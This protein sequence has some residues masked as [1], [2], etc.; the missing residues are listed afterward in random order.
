MHTIRVANGLVQGTVKKVFEKEVVEF[1]CIPYCK[2]PTNELRFQKPQPC[3]TFLDK[4]INTLKFE[5]Y[6]P[7]FGTEGE[8]GENPDLDRWIPKETPDENCLYVNV[9]CPLNILNENKTV[10]VFVWIYGGGF[11]SGSSSLDIYNGSLL[12]T[13]ENIIV[14]NFNYRLGMLGFLC[15]DDPLANGNLGIY[16]QVLALRWIHEN[17]LAFKGDPDNI[18]VAGNS[19]GGCSVSLH[20]LIKESW[21]YYNKAMM[22]S[23]V[24]LSN[25][26]VIPKE[27]IVRRSVTGVNSILKKFNFP[28]KWD[29]LLCT[30]E[31]GKIMKF[32][33]SLNF[34]EFL[35]DNQLA[36]GMLQF[37]WV[38]CVDGDLI[39]DQ[40]ANLLNNGKY[41][42][43]PTVF[44]NVAN[45]GSVF[46]HFQFPKI[47]INENRMVDI[48]YFNESFDYYPHYPKKCSDLIKDKIKKEYNIHEE[49]SIRLL[50][51]VISDYQFVTGSIELANIIS[52]CNNQVY[53]LWMKTLSNS[54][55]WPEWCG[56]MHS[57]EVL[58]LFG[59]SLRSQKTKSDCE[60]ENILEFMK[61]YGQFI[62]EGSFDDCL[63]RYNET[64]KFIIDIDGTNWTGDSFSEEQ[65]N[66]VAFWNNLKIEDE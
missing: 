24:C 31:K 20:L 2:P 26:G 8:I 3:E 21:S 19:A 10:P 36:D 39:T 16:D 1:L 11:I 15:L 28:L 35:I 9:W 5:T 14:V 25:W 62:R 59:L 4:I 33:Q 6:P 63:P 49:L 58:Y 51:K 29:P 48:K 57:V 7:Q 52:R 65:F 32:L 22:Q 42:V 54:P 47:E 60:K 37:A 61:Q 13:Q 53:Y 41:K 38:P 64:T 43:C 44:F 46:I 27:E 17:I 55:Y 45:E 18:T 12:A 66:K 23:G 30:E 56:V 50:D 40:P 34:R